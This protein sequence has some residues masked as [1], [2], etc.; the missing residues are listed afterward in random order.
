[1]AIKPLLRLGLLFIVC[2]IDTFDHAYLKRLKS[3]MTLMTFSSKFSFLLL[4]ALIAPVSFACTKPIVP[5]AKSV[6]CLTDSGIAMAMNAN[7]DIAVVNKEGKKLTDYDYKYIFPS[8]EGL[9]SLVTKD[10]RIG[11]IDS[12]GKVLIP[13][14]FDDAPFIDRGEMSFELDGRRYLY[15]IKT[16]KGV[17]CET[18]NRSDYMYCYALLRRHTEV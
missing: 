14:K 7:D 13:I 6:G 16:A 11:T 8:A 2:H 17:Q 18:G 9:V 4:V 12:Q 3:L 5:D 15:S 10:H 1:M